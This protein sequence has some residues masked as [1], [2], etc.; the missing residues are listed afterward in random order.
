MSAVDA[1]KRCN[2]C[3][4]DLDRTCFR[5]C[6]KFRTRD[7]R[8][9]K[10]IACQK[11]NAAEFKRL[12]PERVK[13]AARRHRLKFR[14]S[15]LEPPARN[16]LFCGATFTPQKPNLCLQKFCCRKHQI[17][18][19][20]KRV[21]QTAWYQRRRAALRLKASLRQPPEFT[22]VQCESRFTATRSAKYCSKRCYPSSRRHRPRTEQRR[23]YYRERRAAGKTLRY[24]RARSKRRQMSP[25]YRERLRAYYHSHKEEFRLRNREWRKK[26]S[27][28]LK[29]LDRQFRHRWR[30]ATEV[31]RDIRR[32]LLD[33]KRWCRQNGIRLR[34]LIA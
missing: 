19:G 23:Q 30:N 29:M 9:T 28:K 11:L 33:L 34:E 22:C 24:E 27:N 7:Q 10:C 13:A 31:E 17:K 32:A 21:S 20:R 2:Q 5:F 4:L 16:C 18:A 25:D 8:A 6:A 12:H 3:G 14:G 15:K 1:L 26:P